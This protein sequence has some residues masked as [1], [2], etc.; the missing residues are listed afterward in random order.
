MPADAIAVAQRR[1]TPLYRWLSARLMRLERW[2]RSHGSVNLRWGIGFGWALIIGIGL[3]LIFGPVINKPIGFD[4]ITASAEDVTG[5]WIAR[6]FQADYVLH[7]GD[8]GRLQVDVTEHI[9]AFFADDVRDET[10]ERVIPTQYES[11]DL[12]PTLTEATLDGSPVHV[13]TRTTADGVAYGIPHRTGLRGDHDVVLRYTLHDMAYAAQDNS[14]GRDEQLWEWNAYGPSFGHGVAETEMHITV[15]RTLADA[16]SRE[17]R[18]GLSWLL[19]ADSAQL[20]PESTTGDTV[21]YTLT[22]DQSL[23]PYAT[24]WFRFAFEPGTFA[25]PAPSFFF[26]VQAIGPFVPLLLLAATLLFALAARAVAWS[27]ARGRAWYVY[28]EE[29]PDAVKPAVAARIWRS[30]LST[31]LVDALDEYRR[32]GDAAAKRALVRAARQAGRPGNLM[33]AWTRYLRGSA[34]KDVFRR[35]LRRVPRGFVRESFLGA[36]LAWA[37]LQAGLVRQLSYQ[38]PLTRYWWPVAVMA[39]SVLVAGTI[40][41]IALTARPLTRK[42]TLVKEQLLGLRLY[43]D[44][45]LAHERISLK[46]PLL[47][48]VVM[49]ASP[50][51]AGR[52]VRALIAQEGLNADVAAD[53]AFL[54]AKRLAVRFA[55]VLAVPAAIAVVSWV[56]ASTQYHSD[57]AA[58]DSDVVPGAYG[59]FVSTFS[60][61]ATLTGAPGGTPRLQVTE[62]LSGAVEEG[63]RNVPQVV[64]IWHDT[65]NGHH[66]GLTVTSVAV[67]G[68]AVPF[69]QSRLDGQALLRTR[70]PDEWP[71]DHDVTIRYTLDD[72]V[73]EVWADGGWRQRLRWTALSP[74]WRFGWAGVDHDVE[75]VSVSL[76]LSDEVLD[77]AAHGRGWLGGG[78][79]P[80]LG[81]RDFGAPARSAAGVQYAE[82]FAPDADGHWPELTAD[83]VVF[84]S[85]DDYLGAQLEF[86]EGTYA[87]GSRAAF[88]ADAAMRA[89]PIVLPV[90]C[91]VIAIGAA[92]IGIVRGRRPIVGGMRD[93]TRWVTPWFAAAAWILTFWATRDLVGDEP[94]FVPIMGSAALAVVATVWMF[95]ATRHRRTPTRTSRSGSH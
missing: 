61:H 28:R 67:D 50:R 26:W 13:H 4:D 84:W 66:A 14:T 33:I 90:L 88:I 62:H 59:F 30:V 47:P 7:R 31:P 82:W 24:F 57:D 72:P 94:E 73:A 93:V 43:A 16:Y 32:G 65:V 56:P 34:W 23:P 51:R 70:L 40:I 41:V 17:P 29:P 55:A 49:F 54:S 53:P 37:V 6:S 60:A 85:D 5:T 3:L 20:D 12:H 45:T 25:L 64:R 52:L 21:T 27:D 48:Y 11:H 63:F 22:N 10:I 8:D 86:P 69:T 42:G 92:L 71:G 2:V 9:T 74:G 15:P 81:V 78:A 18:G 80:D 87:A 44:R 1:P 19:A 46:D 35:G 83:D 77:A 39:V 36:A 68:S 95:V 89:L 91:A 38:V 75:S 76:T 58:Y 79:W